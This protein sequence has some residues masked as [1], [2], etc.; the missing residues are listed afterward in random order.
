[1][2]GNQEKSARP[3]SRPSS[4]SLVQNIFRNNINFIKI[5]MTFGKSTLGFKVQTQNFVV[6]LYSYELI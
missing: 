4:F 2:F 1:M 5:D 6:D 3:R